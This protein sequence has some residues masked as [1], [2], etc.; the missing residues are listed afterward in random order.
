LD[1]FVLILDSVLG[2]SHSLGVD[3]RVEEWESLDVVFSF[4][5]IIRIIFKE[6]F[7]LNLLVP[8]SEISNDL[9]GVSLFLIL[10]LVFFNSEM[11]A[12]GIQVFIS[13][14]SWIVTIT[15]LHGSEDTWLDLIING[16]LEAESSTSMGDSILRS[17]NKPLSVVVFGDS[18]GNPRD[19][20]SN[21]D[22]FPHKFLLSLHLDLESLV[23][24]VSHSGDV[25]SFILVSSDLR[26]H[27]RSVS[28]R[29]LA[30]EDN[31]LPVLVGV[32]LTSDDPRSIRKLVGTGLNNHE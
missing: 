26:E 15:G 19:F 29:I 21:G 9:S 14:R 17:A 23:G 4:S 31:F 28:A 2:E 22:L 20:F 16:V 32:S 27:N 8:D 7:L 5:L 13:H 10:G 25:S 11:D 24:D 18:P 6:I 3:H 30:F 12:I 1:E